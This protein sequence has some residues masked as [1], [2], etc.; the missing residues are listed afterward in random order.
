MARLSSVNVKPRS[1][2]GVRNPQGTIHHTG[3]RCYSAVIPCPRL[4]AD[5]VFVEDFRC[6]VLAA[7]H[8]IDQCCF[9]VASDVS[10][11]SAMEPHI[12]EAA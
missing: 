8:K 1:S 9:N 3:P 12:P 7:S 10:K 2:P 4:T 5:E 11:C 6:S